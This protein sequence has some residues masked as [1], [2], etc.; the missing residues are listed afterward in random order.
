MLGCNDGSKW[1]FELYTNK[2]NSYIAVYVIR[3]K[4]Q[5]FCTFD[6]G[7]LML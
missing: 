7:L 1:Y 6:S 4:V 5:G 2:F 3:Y